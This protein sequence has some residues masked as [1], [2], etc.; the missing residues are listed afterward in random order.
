MKLTQEE[1]YLLTYPSLRRYDLC[2][3]RDA[4]PKTISDMSLEQRRVYLQR[5]A[6]LFV[7]KAA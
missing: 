5:F 4:A 2:A 6:A 7:R 1:A 3:K